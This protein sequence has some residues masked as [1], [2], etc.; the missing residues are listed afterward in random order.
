MRWQSDL[1]DQA[2]AAANV[3]TI[4]FDSKA[5]RELGNAIAKR[6]SRAHS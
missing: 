4:P 1:E 6:V 5:L 2:N 3:V